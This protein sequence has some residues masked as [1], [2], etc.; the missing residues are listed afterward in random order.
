MA[1]LNFN[2][3]GSREP[4]QY[5]HLA[6]VLHYPISIHKALASLDGKHISKGGCGYDFNPQGSR[7]PRLGVNGAF[8]G[9]SEF[10]STRLSRASTI[11][12]SPLFPTLRNFNPQGSREPRRFHLINLYHF[13]QISIHKALASLDSQYD[14]GRK[15]QPHFNPQGSREPRRAMMLQTISFHNISIHKALASLDAEAE[16]VRSGTGQ[17]QSTRLSRASTAKLS[18]NPST[19]P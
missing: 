2:P 16:G 15:P 14:C 8:A 7:E 4:R 11:V 10:Q 1:A 17:F 5:T 13:T 9:R 3:Q 19:S 12:I 18:N 6:L